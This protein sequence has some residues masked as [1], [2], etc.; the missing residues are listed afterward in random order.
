[1]TLARAL[2]LRIP[3]SWAVNDVASLRRGLAEVGLPAFLKRD[4][5]WAGQ[6]VA[7]VRNEAEARQAYDDFGQAHRLTSCLRRIRTNGCRLAL[8]GLREG[9]VPII[10]SFRDIESY[11]WHA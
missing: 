3:K 9:P 5:T 6:G 1:M 11:L 7:R 2:G 8:A 10:E 4:G